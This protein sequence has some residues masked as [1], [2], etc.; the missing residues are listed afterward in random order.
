MTTTEAWRQ[1][2]DPELRR[3]AEG[4]HGAG[5]RSPS[6][7]GNDHSEFHGPSFRPIHL[8]QGT[9]TSTP[10]STSTEAPATGVRAELSCCR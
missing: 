8:G 2:I 10:A 4:D 5:Q 6:R 1:C 9:P 7:F 3:V